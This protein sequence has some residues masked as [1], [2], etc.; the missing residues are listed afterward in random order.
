MFT[1]IKEAFDKLYG[2]LVNANDTPAHVAMGF[3]VGFL[4][5]LMP[6]TGPVAAV[7]VAWYFRLNKAAAI[8]GSLLSNTWLSIVVLG[9]SLQGTAWFFRLSMAD[10]QEKF[11][12]IFKDFHWSHV[13]D[14]FL[15]KITGAV[16]L[17]FVLVSLFLS[18]IA[19]GVCWAVMSAKRRAR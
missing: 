14:P 15:L 8:L 3:A 19:Y 6:F 13:S 7:G 16:I 17:G 9:I 4:L 12:S 2:E 10:L 1:K 5:G 18:V 11:H